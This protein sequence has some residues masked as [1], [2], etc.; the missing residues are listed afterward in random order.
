MIDVRD[1]SKAYGGRKVL[2]TVSLEAPDGCVTGLVGPNGAGKS[3]LLKAI[4]GVSIPDAGAVLIDGMSRASAPQ[5]AQQLGA[6]LSA[7][8]IPPHLTGRA[9]LRFVCDLAHVPAE[10]AQALLQVV[11]LLPAQNRRVRTYSL[12][13]RQRLGI[14]AALAADPRNLILDEPINGL[15][16]E[17]IQWLRQFLV[18][19]ARRGRA[20]LLSSHH[21]AEL[22]LVADRIAVL[23]GGSV[24]RHG[25]TSSFVTAT[26]H[27]VYIESDQLADAVSALERAGHSLAAQGRGAVVRGARPD[28]VG[29]IVFGA[30]VGLTHLSA[31]SKT[32]E[33]TYFETLSPRDPSNGP[34]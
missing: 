13:M 21:M 23:H 34:S 15:D 12:G 31:L 29:R 2:D 32:L 27:D 11:D 26:E 7:E 6:F 9:F 1:V 17:A 24:V 25:S 14:A 20:I 4:A 28:D 3:T 33:Q 19:E 30:R 22:A 10:R 8:V 18:D 5:P 16:P